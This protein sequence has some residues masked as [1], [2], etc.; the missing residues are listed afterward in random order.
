VLLLAFFVL[1]NYADTVTLDHA[2]ISLGEHGPKLQGEVW[3]Y[4]N[5]SGK[6]RL[7]ELK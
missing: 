3:P 5:E 1:N 4:P 6:T 7:F 2:T